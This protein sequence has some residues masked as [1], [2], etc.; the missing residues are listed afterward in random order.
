ML[1]KPPLRTPALLAAN[2]SNALKSTGPRT[3]QGRARVALNALKHGRRAR[4]LGRNLM[5]ANDWERAR[6]YRD[7]RFTILRFMGPCD[8][9]EYRDCER[10]AAEVWC[11]LCR[12]QLDRRT[13]P[14]SPLDSASNRVRLGGISD[15]LCMGLAAGLAAPRRP[16]GRVNIR[17]WRHGLGVTFWV[18]RR[19]FWTENRVLKTLLADDDMPDDWL[20]DRPVGTELEDALRSKIYPLGR[21]T[22][23]E[24]LR[25]GLGP[26][27]THYPGLEML[28]RPLIR[29]LRLAGR[30]PLP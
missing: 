15:R 7:I 19:R 24:R 6:L 20:P 17:S 22:L 8:L 30:W 27:G 1:R 10:M 3:V 2:R 9:F 5:R 29:A 28:C 23:E 11:Q 13:K 18:Q 26:D 4:H 16:W 21:P 25:F 12:L 14:E